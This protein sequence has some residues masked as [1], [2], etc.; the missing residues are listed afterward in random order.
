MS[1]PLPLELR[2]QLDAFRRRLFVQ[3]SLWAG[4]TFLGG[5]LAAAALLFALDRFTETPKW[6]RLFLL[7][8][9]L[10]VAGYGA[11]KWVINWLLH[12]RDD[13]RLSLLVQ[14]KYRNLG[15]NLLSAI[16]LAEGR[17][18]DDT[19]SPE[20]R[21]AA[22]AGVARQ[23][24]AL[25]FARAVNW[26][27]TARIASGAVA[28]LILAAVLGVACLPALRATLARFVNPFA[29]VVRYTFIRFKPMP[30]RVVP[31]GEPFAVDCAIDEASQWKPPT[32]GYQIGSARPGQVP[33]GQ[34][35]QVPGQTEETALK[36]WAGDAK[37]T[38]RIR[39]EARP[40]LTGVKARVEL[41]AYLRLPSVESACGATLTV[42]AGSR[43]AFFGQATRPLAKMDALATPKEVAQEDGKAGLPKESAPASAPAAGLE[44][45]PAFAGSGFTLADLPVAQ[46]ASHETQVTLTWSDTLGLAGAGPHAITVKSRPDQVPEARCTDLAGSVAML[47][48][49]TLSIPVAATDDFGVKAMT[50]HYRF[51]PAK[52][53]LGKD[54]AKE[55]AAWTSGVRPVVRGGPAK[56][57][58][59]GE[60]IFSPKLLGIPEGSVV[61]LQVGAG[62]YCPGHAEGLSQVHR[63]Q[64]MTTSEH[65]KLV[66]DMMI[67]ASG[68]M[69]DMANVERQLLDALAELSKDPAKAATPEGMKHLE[70][71]KKAEQKN[72]QEMRKMDEKLT[73]ITRQAIA[74]K[75]IPKDT[76]EKMA[77][78]SKDMQDAAKESDAA[79]KAMDKA[80][81]AQSPE[82]KKKETD[83]A[84]KHQEE[85]EKKL[86]KNSKKMDDVQKKLDARNFANRLQHEAELQDERSQTA[87]NL[88]ATLAGATPDTMTPEE[89][90]SVDALAD[91]QRKSAVSAKSIADDLASSY[92]RSHHE[93]YQAIIEDME[94]KGLDARNSEL[95]SQYAGNQM[96][97][98]VSGGKE[99]ADLYRAWAKMLKKEGGGGGGGEGGGGDEDSLPAELL[100]TF[101][102]MIESEQNLREETRAVGQQAMAR[103]D[104]LDAKML[105]EAISADE[106]KKQRAVIDHEREAAT[107]VLAVGQE[108][109]L[110]LLIRTHKAYANP[111][112]SE[113]AVDLLPTDFSGEYG[114]FVEGKRPLPGKVLELMGYVGKAMDDANSRL[115]AGQAD[116][117]TIAAQT[118]AIELL[119]SIFDQDGGKG[120]GKPSSQMAKKM[121]KQGKGKGKGD[122]PGK[123]QTGEGTA[124]HEIGD[125]SH[126]DPAARAESNKNAGLE[127]GFV[128][129]EF[130][131][132]ID[133]YHVAVDKM[134]EK[135]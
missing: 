2:Q 1:L 47:P 106:E 57:A 27:A 85:A 64:V 68:K 83:K 90:A 121:A 89:K 21:Q 15:D 100:A 103:G 32:V 97:T 114:T 129:P 60:F 134:E 54:Q 118:E 126:T 135:P 124:S 38:V 19:I 33:A 101:M 50:F 86:R 104:D 8:A 58:I 96:F 84:A 44:L 74:N 94:K 120:S 22:V 14:K 127:G 10:A 81:S 55:P 102:A 24:G 132:D 67:D 17:I 9:G 12:P 113:R 116:G 7:V 49:E 108:D 92:A 79:A 61:E 20:L 76:M 40:A 110:R 95:A 51:A 34:A 63:V 91:S 98:S 78:M 80:Q 56:A 69:D 123:G 16:E 59:G 112:E 6:L 45:T 119:A 111:P 28:G 70:D 66:Q 35:I 99:L 133:A 77:E 48:A 23:A 46:D 105:D 88:A 128:P 11:G 65:A 5:L 72:A 122:K 18:T 13:R 43:V 107:V 52:D 73:D 30:D 41:P 131:G 93:P 39:P 109:Q 62:D 42:V 4:A 31:R 25:D 87:K 130:Q 75:D 125:G 71:I 36:V 82:D 3:E 26:R 37:E 53:V 117:E 29:E 115:K